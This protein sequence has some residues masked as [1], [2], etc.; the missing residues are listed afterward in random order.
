MKEKSRKE[1]RRRES[2]G[3]EMLQVFSKKGDKVGRE[4]QRVLKSNRAGYLEM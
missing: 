2:K 3:K 4:G 1:G